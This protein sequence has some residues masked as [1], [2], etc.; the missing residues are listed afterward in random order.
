MDFEYF[1][2]PGKKFLATKLGI[3]YPSFIKY[4]ILPVF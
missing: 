3:N 1:K 4:K 2:G